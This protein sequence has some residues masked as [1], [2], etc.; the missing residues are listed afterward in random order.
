MSHACTCKLEL[1]KRLSTLEVWNPMLVLHVWSLDFECYIF[2]FLQIYFFVFLSGD[3]QV[4]LSKVVI[5]KD[6]TEGMD[7]IHEPLRGDVNQCDVLSLTA[8]CFLNLW[9]SGTVGSFSTYVSS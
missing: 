2:F 1:R 9:T 7:Y 3:N 4:S 8:V 6:H 5:F